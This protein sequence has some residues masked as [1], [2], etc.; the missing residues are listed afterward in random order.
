MFEHPEFDGHEHR[1]IHYDVASGLKAI[2]AIHNTVRGPALGGCRMIPYAST[3]DA[4]TD[5]LRLSR[6]MTYKSAIADLPLGGGKMVIIGDPK[7]MKT[8]ELLHAAGR[9]IDS[10]HGTYISGEDM[11]MTSADCKVIA[12]VTPHVGG[13]FQ[14]AYA[15][16]PSPIT[17]YGV[18]C[19]MRAAW[20]VYS[21]ATSLKGVVCGI[22]GMGNVGLAL[23][24]RLYQH[25]AI[26]YASDIDHEKLLRATKEMPLIATMSTDALRRSNV[27]IYVPCARGGVIND[28]TIPEFNAP[29]ICGSANNILDRPDHADKLVE[30]GI[31]CVPDYVANCGGLIDI[32][33]QRSGYDEKKVNEHVYKI[34]FGTTLRIL[35]KATK[36]KCSPQ[37]IADKIAESRFKR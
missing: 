37:F 14:T 28:A 24:R 9:F 1:A 6:G 34:A 26:I 11:G 13:V 20:R 2:I 5:A 16:D 33:Y 10:F 31:L 25:G 12:E 15:G 22:E 8:L 21:G 32:H 4:I 17:A 30:R 29:V 19:A 35:R 18:E 3:D 23:A 7:T 27:N 36:M